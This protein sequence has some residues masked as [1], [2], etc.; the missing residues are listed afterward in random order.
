MSSR[1]QFIGI[2]VTI[3]LLTG[4]STAPLQTPPSPLVVVSCPPLTPLSDDSFG[5]TTMKLV[6]VAQQYNKCRKA[7]LQTK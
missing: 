2:V 7:A 3:L 6:E 1:N 5:A 4:C